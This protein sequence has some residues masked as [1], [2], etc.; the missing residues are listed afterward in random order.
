MRYDVVVAGAGAAECV[1]G[2]TGLRVADASVIPDAPSANT[3]L[4]ALM[5]AEK[6]AAA[7][8]GED[9]SAARGS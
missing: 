2:A 9:V 4:P 5:V 1:L 8:A 6:I 3:H 7:I